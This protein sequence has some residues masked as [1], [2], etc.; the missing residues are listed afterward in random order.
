MRIDRAFLTSKVARRI[1][2]LFL[3]CALIPLVILAIVTSNAVDSQLS[4]Q[5]IKRLNQNCKVKGLEIYNNL[6][7]LETELRMFGSSVSGESGIQYR[8][9]QHGSTKG[10][11]GSGFKK[12]VLLNE[13]FKKAYLLDGFPE[14]FKLTPEELDHMKTGRCL[15]RVHQGPK[16]PPKIFMAGLMRTGQSQESFI[17]GE[18][19]P[20]FVWGMESEDDLISDIPMLVLGPK[21][22]ILLSLPRDHPIDSAMVNAI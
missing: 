6:R 7:A 12:L 14:G 13:E 11:S 20:N 5:A 3:L 21:S 4:E 17:L 9:S 22:E 18:V 1:F 2:L 19:E 10:L 15:L 8:P 16:G